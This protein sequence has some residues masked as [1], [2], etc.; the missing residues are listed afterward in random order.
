MGA[1]GY[2][3][4]NDCCRRGY[5][6]HF[7]IALRVLLITNTSIRSSIYCLEILLSILEVIRLKFH[8]LNGTITT[9]RAF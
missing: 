6:E 3:S 8:I 4:G 1:K 5:G 7:H 9:V 2:L